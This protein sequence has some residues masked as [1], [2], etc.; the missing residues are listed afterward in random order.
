MRR[1][2]EEQKIWRGFSQALTESE[3]GHLVRHP[4][5]GGALHRSRSN[6]SLPPAGLR[7]GPGCTQR[8]A[9]LTTRAGCRSGFTASIGQ[10][11]WS[12]IFHTLSCPATRRNAGKS[13]GSSKPELFTEMGPHLG[14]P[15]AHQ[16]FR[17]DDENAADQS[18]QLQF[19][20]DQASFDGF[21]Q[22]HFVG[23]K[24]AAPGLKRRPLAKQESGGEE[25]SPT[26]QSAPEA[27]SPPARPRL[28]RQR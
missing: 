3:P 21:A 14:R 23:Q 19:L 8:A 4:A 28:W 17:S 27:C 6:P 18:A 10:M 5:R 9:P 13:L 26:I 11:I 22:S 1:R 12:Y 16:T 24:Q 15:L 25:E 7:S 20:D 2:G